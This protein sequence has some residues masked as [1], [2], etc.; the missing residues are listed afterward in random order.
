MEVVIWNKGWETA[1]QPWPP[2]SCP[3]LLCHFREVASR[4]ND[5]PAHTGQRL[6]EECGNLWTRRDVRNTDLEV[7]RGKLRVLL[8]LA[9]GWLHAG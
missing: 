5:L 8:M 9:Q 4:G 6:S 2:W 3:S 7:L 1:L